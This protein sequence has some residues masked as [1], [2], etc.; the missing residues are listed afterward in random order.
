LI[1]VQ[2]GERPMTEQEWLELSHPFRLLRGLGRRPSNRKRRLFACAS[3]RHIWNL[4]ADDDCRT[5]VA[6][7][8]READG[9]VESVELAEFRAKAKAASEQ[10]T[11]P[12]FVRPCAAQAC[13]RAS[14]KRPGDAVHAWQDAISAV[15]RQVWSEH[16]LSRQGSSPA[17]KEIGEIMK[18]VWAV[19]M[20][21][22]VALLRDIFGNPF[23]PV[24]V[25]PAWLTVTVVS[26]ATAIYDD[27]AF[28]RLPI[29][30][31]A[32][33]DAG[34]D[35]ADILNHCRQPGEHV[36]GCFVVDLVLGKE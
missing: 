13:Y 21:R 17:E 15:Q 1:V 3:C 4:I 2:L 34:C 36:R 8:E 35:Q 18:E 23:R 14:K 11:D 6:V 24:T 9:L 26:L 12:Y 20:P 5:A 32:L 10:H 28:D 30:A 27:R 25:D 16:G 19:E 31:D 22:H 7:A 29:L 33:E